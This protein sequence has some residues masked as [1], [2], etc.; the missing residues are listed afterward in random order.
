MQIMIKTLSGDDFELEVEQ[1][2]NIASVKQL[3]C[4]L[5]NIPVEEQQLILLDEKKINFIGIR[6]NDNCILCNYGENYLIL[7]LIVNTM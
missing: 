1:T 7:Q 2:D 5:K 3:I 4:E 6:L